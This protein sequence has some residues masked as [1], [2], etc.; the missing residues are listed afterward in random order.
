M[1]DIAQRKLIIFPS[2]DTSHLI[3][4]KQ[5]ARRGGRQILLARTK[6]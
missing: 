3:G 5:D 2:T 6:Q 1:D 4:H